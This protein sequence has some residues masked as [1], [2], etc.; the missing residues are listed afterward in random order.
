MKFGLSSIAIRLSLLFAFGPQIQTIAV[1]SP[2]NLH[3]NIDGTYLSIAQPFILARKH[4]LDAGWKPVKIYRNVNYEYV[5][6]ENR[7][8]EHGFLEFDACSIDAGSLCDFYYRKAGKCLR[9]DTVG[10][11]VR[12]MK[13]LQWTHECPPTQQTIQSQSGAPSGK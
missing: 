1:A 5:G 7:L 6:V 12:D 10:E 13:V 2:D 4:L 9:V 3:R 8:V 11:Q